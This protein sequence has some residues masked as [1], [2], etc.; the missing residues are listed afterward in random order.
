MTVK[1]LIEQLKVCRDDEIVK[2]F[3][4]DTDEWQEV[5]GFTYGGK[6]GAVQLY[7]DGD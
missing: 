5:T 3:D 4:P 1:Q 6:D 2:I 7:C